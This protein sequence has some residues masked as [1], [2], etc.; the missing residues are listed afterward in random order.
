MKDIDEYG[1]N[2][3]TRARFIGQNTRCGLSKPKIPTTV[4]KIQKLMGNLLKVTDNGFNQENSA[5][6][7]AILNT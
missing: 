4:G 3:E 5:A 7:L 2:L 6:F 1:A